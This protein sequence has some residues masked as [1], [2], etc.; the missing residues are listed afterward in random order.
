MHSAPIQPPDS[1]LPWGLTACGVIAGPCPAPRRADGAG[2]DVASVAIGLTA[3]LIGLA[4]RQRGHHVG[5]AA[6][7]RRRIR[8]LG[9]SPP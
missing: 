9:W 1:L 5:V 2:P 7:A 3:L 8:T 6:P 4:L